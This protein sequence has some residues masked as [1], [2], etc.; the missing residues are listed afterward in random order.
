MLIKKERN[1]FTIIKLI[2]SFFAKIS[3]YCL[4]HSDH[5]L[6]L[7]IPQIQYLPVTQYVLSL[8]KPPL[9][10]NRTANRMFIKQQFFSIKVFFIQIFSDHRDIV[11]IFLHPK[12]N[13]QLLILLPQC[14]QLF[15]Y[16]AL[17]S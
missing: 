15:N 16:Q 2:S 10:S 13:H 17:C 6:L 9:S 3:N 12:F 1:N 7:D 14:L 5:L 4:Q 11:V 8:F